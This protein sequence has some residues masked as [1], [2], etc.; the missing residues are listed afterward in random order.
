LYNSQVPALLRLVL[1]LALAFPA[2][3][4]SAVDSDH[5]GLSDELEQTL[6][7]KFRP[8]FMTSASDC[9]VRP[10]RF[11]AGE[12]DP[13]PIA[14]DGTIYGQVFP[15][16]NHRIEVHYYMLW[17]KDCGRISHP[18]DAEHVAA[19]I[20]NEG[21]E[22]KALYWYTG[23]HERTVCDISSGTRAQAVNAASSGPTI[24]S[25][26]G[27]HALYFKKEMCAHGCGADSCEDDRELAQAGDV[28]NVGELKAPV[29]GAL[30]TASPRWLLST[31]MD[32]D[33]PPEVIAL[34]DAT[35]SEA[36]STLRGRSTL[37]GTIQGSGMVYD[38]ISESAATGA[39]HTEAA[40]DT[41]NTQTSNS[42]DK[43]TKATGN[44]LTRAWHFIFRTKQQQ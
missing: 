38:N 8:T 16:A 14:A 40:L 32:T 26:S 9:A 42:L 5:D 6:L 39:H 3:A 4:Q 10:A 44:A 7:A 33:F 12:A 35:P 19:L 22:P 23:A 11:K 36:I 31:K 28:V 2:I 25:A 1:I 21:G 34:I 29:N 24:W 18:L 30:F 20:S 43:A 41:A 15:T 17:D 27:K 13:T 37:R